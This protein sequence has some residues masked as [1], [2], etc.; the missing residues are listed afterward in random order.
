MNRHAMSVNGTR[1]PQKKD[2]KIF[3][4]NFGITSLEQ[5]LEE[6]MESI[7]QWPQWAEQAG[8]RAANIQ[9]GK[10]RLQ[11]SLASVLD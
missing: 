8:C 6:V 10:A 9:K 3:A 5:I 4:E 11:E 2:L 7:K 1:K